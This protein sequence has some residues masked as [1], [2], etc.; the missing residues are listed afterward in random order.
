MKKM[1]KVATQHLLLKLVE[2]LIDENSRMRNT[3][4]HLRSRADL[5]FGRSQNS[6][7]NKKRKV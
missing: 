5:E 3:I 6:T 7:K 2:Y 4:D 1:S